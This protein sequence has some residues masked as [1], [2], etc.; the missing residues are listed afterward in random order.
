[1]RDWLKQRKTLVNQSCSC[2][3]RLLLPSFIRDGVYCLSFYYNMNGFH[4]NKLRVVKRATSGQL[5]DVWVKK[6]NQGRQWHSVHV[7]ADL[8]SSQQVSATVNIIGSA[9]KCS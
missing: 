5:V 6:H 3:S 1:M 8:S 7:T 4:V 2:C 9:S